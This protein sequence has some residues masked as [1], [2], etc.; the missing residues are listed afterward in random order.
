MM[1]RSEPAREWPIPR[2][3]YRLPPLLLL[4]GEPASY[5]SSGVFFGGWIL[6]A[7]SG[8]GG[9]LRL[10]VRAIRGMQRVSPNYQVVMSLLQS[11]EHCSY[12]DIMLP[13]QADL[14]D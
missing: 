11:K 13:G 5:P 9:A 14:S 6:A 1:L 2:Q 8:M 12:Y 3:A 4:V 10:V 7:R